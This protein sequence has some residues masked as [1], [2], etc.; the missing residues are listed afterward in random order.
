MPKFISIEAM[1]PA[2]GDPLADHA[3]MEAIKEPVDA[4][5]KA[6]HGLA[7]PGNVTVRHVGKKEKPI[8]IVQAT[9][10]AP[11]PL[12]APVVRSASRPAA[13]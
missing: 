12:V 7:V 13:E 2:T 8:E 4:L 10:A 5:K 9:T 11:E 6:V 3:I 1:I